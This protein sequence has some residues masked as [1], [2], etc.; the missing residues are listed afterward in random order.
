MLLVWGLFLLFCS[1]LEPS[2]LSLLDGE[3]VSVTGMQ[4]ALRGDAGLGGG[5]FLRTGSQETRR[6][7]TSP[8]S[9]AAALCR[10]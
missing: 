6:E 8:G 2:R 5:S 10:G 9:V 3:E 7:L 1:Q 4:S